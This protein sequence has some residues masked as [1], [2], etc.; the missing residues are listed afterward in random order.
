M[1]LILWRHAEAEE[2]GPD[3]ERRLTQKGQRQ[4]AK[5]AAFLRSRLPKNTRIVVSPALRARQTVHALTR[6]FDTEAR[7]GPGAS[8][9]A[10]LEA[11]GWPDG[12]A[13]CTLLVGHQPY[14]GE[15]AALLLAGSLDS[16]SIRK[17]AVW[18]LEQRDAKPGVRLVMSPDLV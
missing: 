5:M 8:A 10:A 15:I 7:I 6:H 1:E 3:L 18:W 14:L 12:D 11:A 17:G 16:F 2:G 4:A 9:R 13:A